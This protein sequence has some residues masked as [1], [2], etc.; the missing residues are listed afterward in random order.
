MQFLQV[1]EERMK[2]YEQEELS[3]APRDPVVLDKKLDKK[4]DEVRTEYEAM[5]RVLRRKNIT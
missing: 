5:K 2:T 3:K 4:H 1:H